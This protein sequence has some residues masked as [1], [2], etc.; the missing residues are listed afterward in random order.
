MLMKTKTIDLHAVSE[1]HAAI[2]AKLVN[3]AAWVKP[4][5]ASWCSPMFRQAQSN[6]RQ[7]HAPE[8]RQT[9]DIIGA[10]AIEKAVCKLP[11]KHRDAIRWHYVFPVA[12]AKVCRAL[13][14]SYEGLALLVADGR[15]M[16]INR[17][18]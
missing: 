13:G 7:W 1:K 11:E 17:G 9:C 16:L 15:T 5:S 14:V 12:P 10:Q 4:R 2:D 18:C 8:I 6:S 3:W